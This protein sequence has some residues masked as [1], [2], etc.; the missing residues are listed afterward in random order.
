MRRG[1]LAIPVP[2][3]LVSS[4]P[5]KADA[6]ISPSR[7]T[8]KGPFYDHSTPTRPRLTYK[9]C[10]SK[11]ARI[12][13]RNGHGSCTLQHE[14]AYRSDYTTLTD[15]PSSHSTMSSSSPMSESSPT[16]GMT[17][18][19][20]YQGRSLRKKHPLPSPSPNSRLPARTIF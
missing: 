17:A 4:L 5:E 12:L 6:L 10:P 3:R 19:S 7:I 9:H 1:N 2:R 15:Y 18:V 16:A 14:Q 11:R 20:R 13:P 8:A